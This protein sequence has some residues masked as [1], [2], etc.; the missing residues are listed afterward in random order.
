MV[1]GGSGCAKN[2]DGGLDNT[3]CCVTGVIENQGDCS[4]TGAAP[5]VITGA[6]QLS[7]IHI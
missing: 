5:C 6:F 2:G 3:D 4:D 1:T 7:L